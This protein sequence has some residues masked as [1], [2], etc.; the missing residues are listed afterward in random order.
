M[1]SARERE[2]F[3]ELDA[4]AVV[5]VYFTSE[6]GEIKGFA[7]KLPLELEGVLGPVFQFRAVIKFT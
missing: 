6:K 4:D 3:L 1:T 5:Y 7:V 2:Y